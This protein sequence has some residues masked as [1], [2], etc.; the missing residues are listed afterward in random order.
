VSSVSFGKG[1]GA[2][3]D[4][5]SYY[6]H[7]DKEA[8]QA[9][10]ERIGAE[11]TGSSDAYGRSCEGISELEDIALMIDNHAYWLRPDEYLV[12]TSG[13]DYCYSAFQTMEQ[14]VRGYE[15]ALGRIFLRKYF[16]AY[17]FAQHRVGFALAN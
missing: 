9:I 16:S 7:L 8:T 17:N 12:R 14:P 13:N 1:T 15:A 2:L 4:L 3:V 6:I 5:N 11:K 10:N